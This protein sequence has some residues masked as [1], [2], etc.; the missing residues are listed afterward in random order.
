MRAGVLLRRSTLF[1]CLLAGLGPAT[2]NAAEQQAYAAAMN[3]ATPALVLGK[4][5][6][7]TFTNLD[8]LA[9]HD[10]LSDEGK[11]K[12]KL[13]GAGESTPVEGVDKLSAGNYPFHCSLHSWMRGVVTVNEAGGAPGAPSADVLTL[14]GSTTPVGKANVAPD[15]MD[16][17]PRAEPE[18]IGRASWPFYGK[19]LANSR[20]GGSGGPSLAEVGRLGPAWSFYSEDG[21][22]TS[23]PVVHRGYVVAGSNGGRV[24]AL[25]GSTGEKVWDVKLGE[26]PINGT[27]AVSGKRV[28]VPVARPHAPYVVALHLETGK[29]LWKRA[30]VLDRQKDADVYGSPVVWRNR[31]Y[32]GVSSLYGETG[33][34]EVAVRGAV[35][36]LDKK[37]GKRKWKTYMVPEKHDG[38]S[39]W[40]T[41]AIDPRTG[42]LYVGTGNAYHAPAA[43]T[44]D[45]IVALSARTGRI[46]NHYQATADDVWN[47]TENAA[48]GPDYD[49]GAS[50]NLFTAPDGTPMVGEGQKSG[51]YWALDRRTM[52][53]AWSRTIA[54]GTPVIGGVI[55]ST[56]SDGKQVYGPGTHAGEI[57][58][59]GLEGSYKWLSADGGP[60]RFN[61]VAVANGVVWTTDMSG[62]LTARDAATGAVAVRMPL[63]S[64]TWAGVSIAG[65]SVFVAIGTEGGAGYLV[66][67]RVRKGDHVTGRGHNPAADD[68][69]PN[70][71]R[72]GKER[73]DT[74]EGRSQKGDVPSARG[75]K[76]HSRSRR[77]CKRVRKGGRTRR[78]CRRVKPKKKRA[79]KDQQHSNHDHNPGKGG[80]L[81]KGLSRRGDRFVPKR[82]G[83][84]EE[85]TFYYGPYTVP[86]GQDLNRADI[87]LPTY[88]GYLLSV[89]PSMRRVTDLSEPSH[90]QAH[91]HHSHWFEGEPGSNNAGDV[92]FNGNAEWI[93]GNGDEETRGDF[94][95]RSAADPDGPVY[96]QYIPR[97]K[98]QALVYM[99]HNK[100][101][102]PL[103]VYIVL[104]VAFRHGT[105]KEL[106][107]Q[108]GRP[109]RDVAGLLFG[110]T[111]DVPR[112][113]D[114]DGKYE[115]AKEGLGQATYTSL[116]ESAGTPR[117]KHIELVAPSDGVII[118]MG[119]H[120]H[121]GGL[122]VVVENYGS[123]K[124]PCRDDGRGYGGTLLL[125]SDARFRNAP[126]SEDFQ[127]EVSHPGYRAPIRKGD[128][129]RISGTY[130]NR[131]H[132]WYAVM[133]HLGIY[134]DEEQK[135][136]AGCR[137]KVINSKKWN[138]VDGVLNRP[139][140][141]GREDP[142]CGE[143]FGGPPCERWE[144]PGKLREVP[145]TR[146]T[147]ANFAYLPGNRAATEEAGANTGEIP[148]VARGTPLQFVNADQAA[149]IR[150]TVTTCEWPCNGPYVGNYPF[151]DGRWD[152][153]VMGY[154]AVD[155]GSASPVTETP[156]DLAPGDYA[157]FCRIHPW[158]R[159]AFRIK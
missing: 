94:R 146:V 55:G 19:D 102:S 48:E 90:Q 145:A 39:V 139:K 84:T 20:D 92:Y 119:G 152:S 46:I 30:A 108:T 118:G 38:G 58:S 136:W 137:P 68:G 124:N 125:N 105:K 22:F 74:R 12:S 73:G 14:D 104:D 47:G 123:R 158:M 77:R 132:A 100:T 51:V 56:A 130:E 13:V 140:W 64:P 116:Q 34:A 107:A 134:V 23:T 127:M 126:Y 18:P 85:L 97:G 99:L 111:F 81:V 44:T 153:G 138:P 65:G 49:F 109:H 89:D 36:A 26:H 121:P 16:L 83:T 98:P 27:V 60:L 32:I 59:L 40:S 50:P 24:Y 42:V 53:P 141:G 62:Y 148:V 6:K 135:P 106:E 147:I 128:R 37:T 159:G 61:P 67:Y 72:T 115:Y 33:D 143:A 155:R 3:Y 7:L 1:A 52:K 86:P 11:F 114:G 142:F 133:T 144:D 31:V 4:G 91:I 71:E 131:D 43:P 17:A 157:Y 96:G 21:D 5:D 75:E 28:Y 117:K 151:A 63:G 87:E 35:V 103:E 2:A 29:K 101:A 112:Q 150:H 122:R 9:K 54:V 15:P 45:A 120:L 110:R 66:S 78:V 88:E 8:T 113:P 156:K 10:L 57:W 25:D 80:G 70:P 41:P 69:D 76:R 95:Q 93:F 149:A 129:I 79:R 154:D 82:P